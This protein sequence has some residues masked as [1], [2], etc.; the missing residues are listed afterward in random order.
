MKLVHYSDTE[1]KRIEYRGQSRARP[2]FKPAGLWVSDDEEYGWRNWC[3]DEG[4]QISRLVV[5]HE[6][7]LLKGSNVLII[8]THEE[9]QDFT[10]IYSKQGVEDFSV[11]NWNM[12]RNMH[13][14]LII[15]PYLHA[16]RL[17]YMWYYSWDCASGCIWNPEV[18]MV[19]SV[20]FMPEVP[21]AVFK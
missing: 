19:K 3:V 6:I 15:T 18:V 10:G 21:V 1:I 11:I 7:E 14:G 13:D 4:F 12:V 9:L 5:A 16:V 17:D 2:E 20:T 8:A